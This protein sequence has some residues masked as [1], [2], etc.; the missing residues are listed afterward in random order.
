[1][2]HKSQEFEGGGG[3]GREVSK[4]REMGEEKN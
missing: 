3:G 2:I 4:V 1:M